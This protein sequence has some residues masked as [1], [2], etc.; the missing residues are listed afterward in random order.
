M[1]SIR[2]V[3]IVLVLVLLCCSGCS[4]VTFGYNHAGWML[5][6]WINGYTSFTPQQ[7]EDIRLDVAD[8]MRWHREK[9]L[10]EYTAFLQDLNTAT[11]KNALRDEDVV[12]VRSELS[13]LYRLT[14]TPMIRPA[15]HVLSTLDN[16][17][18]DEL[19]QTLAKRDREERE[20]ALS[21]SQQEN[22]STRSD[23]YVHFTEALVGRLSDEQEKKIREMSLR[24]PFITTS[25]FEQRKTK[26]ARLISLLIN[27][28]G[29]DSIAAFFSQWI[30]TPPT[31][32]SPQ[33]QQA[34]EAWDSTMNGMIVR[35]FALLTAD[36]K[37]HL[38]KKISSYID[39]LQKLHSASETLDAARA[40]EPRSD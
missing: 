9:A 24:I 39:D 38:H 6:H 10:P 1:K 33:E 31:P 17:Q 11:Q 29:E 25:Y 27:H 12:H 37:D 5:R 14:M 26:Q 2:P 30:N 34:L 20:E 3:F 16:R 21:G 32:A 13:R 23:R 4:R 40:T 19:R 36:Q 18:I 15:A 22:L 35:I 28:V 8:Y 7:K